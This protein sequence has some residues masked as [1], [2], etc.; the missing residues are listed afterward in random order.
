MSVYKTPDYDHCIRDARFRHNVYEPE[1]D[2]FLFMEALDHDAALL[3][4]LSPRRCLEVGCGSGSVITHLAMLLLLPDVATTP[5]TTAATP[6][7]ISEGVKSSIADPLREGALP[8][9]CGATPSP[10]FF[11]VDVNP[12]ALEAA[13]LT[14]QNTVQ[15]HL[16]SHTNCGGEER[17]LP[18]PQ[19]V[20]LAQPQKD[21]LDAT[22]EGKE[23]RAISACGSHCLTLLQGDLFAP[24]TNSGRA[25][26]DR[27]PVP[28]AASAASC[29][30]SSG[31]SLSPAVSSSCD[32][33]TATPLFDIILFN[34]PYVPTSMQELEDAIAQ[35]DVITAAWCGGPRGRVVLDRFIASLPRYLSRN[36]CCYM[37][38][39]KENDVPDVVA[40]TQ[41]T[42]RQHV[43]GEAVAG[44]EE[45]VEVVPIAERYTGEH[46]SVHRVSYCGT[47]VDTV[48][49]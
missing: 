34:P 24:L 30:P 14:W 16:F 37:V 11:A 48:V 47:F 38:L 40:Y 28:M 25:E 19:L 7:V 39:I 44:K 20:C 1:A 42:F 26:V 17:G 5:V 2:T 4:Q 8:A 33:Q 45:V 13:A 18:P 43:Y 15:K 12:L 23:S 29:S 3:R 10:S 27:D 22:T 21:A 41:R 36:G 49:E 46:L 9:G 35:R 6:S 31:A 32:V